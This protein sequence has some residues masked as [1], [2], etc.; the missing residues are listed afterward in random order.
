MRENIIYDHD[1]IPPKTPIEKA[2]QVQ[3][4]LLANGWVKP[5]LKGYEYD[6]PDSFLEGRYYTQIEI[7]GRPKMGVFIK[8]GLAVPNDPSHTQYCR[9]SHFLNGNHGQQD[10]KPSW[11][12]YLPGR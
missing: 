8:A 10:K 6:I 11:Y 5:E 3:T 12:S 2:K 4:S 7:L 9:V 1:V